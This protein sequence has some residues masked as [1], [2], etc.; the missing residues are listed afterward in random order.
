MI[1][2]V[3]WIIFLYFISLMCSLLMAWGYTCS[4]AT[5]KQTRN[6]KRVWQDQRRFFS[7][8][9]QKWQDCLWEKSIAYLH[10]MSP[11]SLRSI[12]AIP[13]NRG[14]KQDQHLYLY[15]FLS[16]KSRQTAFVQE[17]QVVGRFLIP[18]ARLPRNKGKQAIIYHLSIIMYDYLIIIFYYQFFDI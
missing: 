4:T 8:E 16:G 7:H 11:S 14:P 17:G 15:L 2:P 5:L 6:T 12:L 13:Q 1:Q 3:S 18:G 9:T 10:L